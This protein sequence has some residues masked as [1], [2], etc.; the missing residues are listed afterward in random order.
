MPSQSS[1]NFEIVLTREL[2]YTVL[3]IIVMSYSY[4]WIIQLRLCNRIETNACSNKELLIHPQI[5]HTVYKEK[6]SHK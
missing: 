1:T 5:S 2:S 6:P 3:L 4:H